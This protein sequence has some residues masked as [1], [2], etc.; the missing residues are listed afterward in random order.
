MHSKAA[1]VFWTTLILYVLT[2]FTVT[3][4]GVYLTYIAIPLIVFSGLVMKL[5]TPKPE[6]VEAVEQTKEVISETKNMA[7]SGLESLS[8]LMAEANESL[9]DSNKINE[10]T[11]Q[12]TEKLKKKRH[13]LEL[14]L[15]PLREQYDEVYENQSPKARKDERERITKELN[16]INDAIQKIEKACELEVLSHKI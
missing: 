8:E 13:S 10:L 15:I 16:H 6:Y 3:Y 12:R 5:T 4:V 11:K 2:L 1:F 7:K 14:E 9:K